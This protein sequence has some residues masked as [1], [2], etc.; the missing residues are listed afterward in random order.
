MLFAL[1]A[2]CSC[3]GDASAGLVDEDGIVDAGYAHIDTLGIAQV[4]NLRVHDVL[5]QGFYRGDRPEI[6]WATF[7]DDW[8]NLYTHLRL[9]QELQV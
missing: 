1:P 6:D 5:K 4:L 3:L 2:S 7:E 8:L 9:T